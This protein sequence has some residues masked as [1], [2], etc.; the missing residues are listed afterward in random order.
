M[1]IHTGLCY[2]SGIVLG[3][4]N[5]LLY[6]TECLPSQGLHSGVGVSDNTRE[7][8]CKNVVLGRIVPSRKIKQDKEI[9]SDLCVCACVCM[10]LS[11]SVHMCLLCARVSL[12]GFAKISHLLSS[13]N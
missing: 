6:R 7:Q 1:P 8:A 2:G 12:L 11:V 4:E 9:D 13:C 10:C 3:V 5:R